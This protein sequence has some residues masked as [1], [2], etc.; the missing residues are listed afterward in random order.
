MYWLSRTGGK[1]IMALLVRPIAEFAI[2]V[3][4]K[5]NVAAVKKENH[6]GT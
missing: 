4:P 3:D 6:A 2:V 5:D 1:E